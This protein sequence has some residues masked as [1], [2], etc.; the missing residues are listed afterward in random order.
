MTDDACGED[1]RERDR[2]PAESADHARSNAPGLASLEG[3]VVGEP[4]R[5]LPLLLDEREA[6]AD[7]AGLDDLG[8]E[9]AGD[10]RPGGSQTDLSDGVIGM[11]IRA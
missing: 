9:G 8:G 3:P 7:S 2:R 11:V 6:L 10:V 4:A 5:L 1:E